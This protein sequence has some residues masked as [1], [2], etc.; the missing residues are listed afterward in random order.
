M[1]SLK[2]NKVA[3]TLFL[4]F[5]LCCF[6]FVGYNITVKSATQSVKVPVTSTF[7]ESGTVIKQEDI[8]YLEISKNLVNKD[9]YTTD[10][11][12]GMIVRGGS[13]LAKGSLFYAELLENPK[14]MRNISMYKLNANEVALP[15]EVNIET[16]YNNALKE[17]HVID[18]Y[19]SG[20]GV[21]E[22]NEKE[23]V[24]YGK[25]VNNVRILAVYDKDGISLNRQDASNAATVIVA[26]NTDEADLI[27]RAK[28][29]GT[30]FP[31]VSYTAM[32][33]IMDNYYDL[34]KMRNAI[35]ER[36]ID[37]RLVAPEAGH[38]E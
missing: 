28:V 21:E 22:E 10:E 17:G 6:A 18:L 24:I 38:D 36:T 37:I 9:I 20:T 7:L 31:V 35:Y 30:V 25:L 19:F 26:L 16:S 3:M 14:E 13:S 27:G 4:I 15:I 29:F 34:D 11:L 23:K 1:N 2:K 33:Q 32:N 5:G 12:I 8:T